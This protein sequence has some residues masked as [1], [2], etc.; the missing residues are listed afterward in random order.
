MRYEEELTTIGFVAAWA[1]GCAI[2]LVGGIWWF[3]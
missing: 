2:G 1:A 3:G